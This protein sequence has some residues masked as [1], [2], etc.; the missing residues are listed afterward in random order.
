MKLEWNSTMVLRLAILLSAI[1]LGTLA[2]PSLLPEAILRHLILPTGLFGARLVCVLG[3]L[4]FL[5]S[6]LTLIEGAAGRR[7]QVERNLLDG[8]L[9]HIP[10]NVFFKDLDSR[11]VRIGSAMAK[12][13]GLEDPAQALNKTDADI[14]SGEHAEQALADE[15]EIIRTGRAMFGKEEKE[16]WPDGHE[17]W[18]LT[19]KVPLRNQ[20]GQIVGTMGIAHDITDRK[21]AELQIRHMALHDSLTGLP[22]RLLL[23]DRLTQAVAAAKRTQHHVAVMML[24]LD[25]FKNV[26]DSFGHYIGDRLLESVAARLTDCS[27]ES[28][29]VARLGGDEFVLALSGFSKRDDVERVA[30]K[31]LAALS[32]PFQI[33]GREVQISASIGIAQFPD[34]GESSDALLQCADAAMYDAKKCGRGRFCFFSAALTEATRQQ[35]K[36]EADLILACKRHEFILHYQ[37]FIDSDSGHITGMEALLRWQHPEHG[38]ISP[39]QFIPQLEELELMP[40]VGSWVLKTACRQAVEW[41]RQGLP[42]IR[43]AINV[44]SQQF[45]QGN[46]VNSVESALRDTQ[47]DPGLLELELTESRILNDSEATISI[48]RRLKEI[49]VSLSLD[50][51]GT[52]WSSLS[53]LRQFPIDRIKIDRSFVRDLASQPMA[54]AMVKSIISLGQN[55]SLT[56]IAEGVETAKQ[57]EFLRNQN[58]PEMQGFYFSRPLEA[59][60]ATALLRSAK[61]EVNN[62][63]AKGRR[64]AS[65]H[66]SSQSEIETTVPVLSR[67]PKWVQ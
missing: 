39:G 20:T 9:E 33:E 54:E 41:Q 10:D 59:H 2:G 47:L 30:G 35:E 11:F 24:D 27:R 55:L 15:R 37:P 38:L 57:R 32:Q 63:R 50:D 23:E 52:G 13:C 65:L 36:L 40:E 61:F 64:L 56:C 8:F 46:I 25:R 3:V 49:G 43:M 42:S 7:H 66:P 28:D 22:N 31:I 44:S 16:T 5:Y 62:S 60:D 34:D 53:Y 26:N 6:C 51:F 18:V 45:Y 67:E 1:L 4:V 14:F 17:T 19:T 21:Q 48:L 29:T 12:Y 58:C